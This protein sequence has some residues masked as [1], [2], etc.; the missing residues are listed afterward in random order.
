MVVVEGDDFRRQGWWWWW[1]KQLHRSDP[2]PFGTIRTRVDPLHAN[3]YQGYSM[4]LEVWIRTM[5]DGADGAACAACAGGI[6]RRCAS[7]R[8]LR[9]SAR[10]CCRGI[11]VKPIPKWLPCW[12]WWWTTKHLLHRFRLCR[13]L[14]PMAEE[15]EKEED[16]GCCCRCCCP[17]RQQQH[18]RRG[19]T[20]RVSWDNDVIRFRNVDTHWTN[21]HFVVRWQSHGPKQHNRTT[22]MYFCPLN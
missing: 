21:R 15:E 11:P 4:R 1:W 14:C 10:D 7:H 8:A 12:C 6:G 5:I 3:P 17:M 20:T 19:P 22:W 16:H 13:R 9:H 18:V 2:V